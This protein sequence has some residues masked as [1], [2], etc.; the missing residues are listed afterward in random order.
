VGRPGIVVIAG[1]RGRRVGGADKALLVLDGR[2]LLAH[3]LDA[4]QALDVAA[5]C[6]V[7]VVGPARPGFDGVTWACEEPPGSGP[8][9]ALAAGLAALVDDADPVL[10][11]GGDMPHV[12][13][14][15]SALLAALTFGAVAV[16]VDRDDQ[17]QPLASAWRRAALAQALERVGVR[18]D[19][20]LKRLLEGVTFV[21]VAD[22]EGATAD[23]DSITDLDRLAGPG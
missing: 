19:V 6:P 5:S 17:V 15:V 3:V 7:V 4:A 14:G 10:V 12:A 21:R 20:P 13:R 16:L 1:G 18:E 11:L 9:A 23:V 22:L 2:P 8:L